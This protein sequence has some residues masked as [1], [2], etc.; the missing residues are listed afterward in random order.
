MKPCSLFSICYNSDA[1]GLLDGVQSR[2]GQEMAG[3]V[4]VCTHYSQSYLKS[5][6]AYMLINFCVDCFSASSFFDSNTAPEL[7]KT[8]YIYMA[9]L[10]K[11][12]ERVKNPE[13]SGPS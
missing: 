6:W 5:I 11:I 4:H 2:I 10:D 9:N 12:S 7:G 1:Q 3:Q 13:K 8:R